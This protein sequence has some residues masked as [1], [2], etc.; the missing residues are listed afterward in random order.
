[1]KISLEQSMGF[2]RPVTD[3][4]ATPASGL[5]LGNIVGSLLTLCLMLLLVLYLFTPG[6]IALMTEISNEQTLKFSLQALLH[7]LLM[8]FM[9]ALPGT[10]LYQAVLHYRRARDLERFGLM[11]R[12]YILNRWVYESEWQPTHKIQYGYLTEHTATQIVD[13]ATYLELEH[14][15]TVFVLY[16]ENMPECSQ[17]DL[18]E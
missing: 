18:D 11:T 14:E 12:G 5:L 13:R 10:W 9:V 4:E 17:L 7:I 15:T 16:L 2:N 8:T 3:H 1:M 6:L